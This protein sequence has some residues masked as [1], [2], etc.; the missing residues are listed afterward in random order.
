MPHQYR[1]SVSQRKSEKSCRAVLVRFIEPFLSAGMLASSRRCSAPTPSTPPGR[2]DTSARSYRPGCRPVQVIRAFGVIPIHGER[3]PER[4]PLRAEIHLG[5]EAKLVPGIVGLHG[6]DLD[7]LL[8]SGSHPEGQRVGD[9]LAEGDTALVELRMPRDGPESVHHEPQAGA[10][11]RTFRL[12]RP[13]G[14]GV[15]IALQVPG[16]L[17][18]RSEIAVPQQLD[19]GGDGFRVPGLAEL[20]RA[21]VFLLEPGVPEVLERAGIRLGKPIDLTLA[22]GRM[23]GVLVVDLDEGD[24]GFPG[25][26]VPGVWVD[27]RQEVAGVL[28]LKLDH[29]RFEVV[30]PLVVIGP[31]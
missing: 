25:I 14:L 17:E 12:D 2:S 18:G 19:T 6:V 4:V 8:F 15:V 16:A 31:L 28:L 9:I 1:A 10:A 26:G 13:F 24:R 23:E 3:E 5:R 21:A 7:P 29:A 20:L 22:P 11:F 30:E 27:M